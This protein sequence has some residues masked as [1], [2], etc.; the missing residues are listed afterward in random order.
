MAQAQITINAVA[1]SNDDLPIATL[2]QLNNNNGG[3]EI[4]YA[5]SIIDQPPGAADALSNPAIQNPTLTP[6]KEGTYLLRLVVNAGPNQLTDEVI[7]AVR[8]VKSRQ[9][10]PAAGEEAEDGARGWAGAIGSDMSYLDSQLNLQAGT[11]VVYNGSGSTRS[12]GEVVQLLSQ[13]T[14]KSGLPGQELM[15]SAILAAFGSIIAANDRGAHGPLALVETQPDG[16][17]TAP[18][19]SLMVVRVFGMFTSYPFGSMSASGLPLAL[20][21]AGLLQETANGGIYQGRAMGTSLSSGTNFS[22]FFNGLGTVPSV[23]PI[24]FGSASQFGLGAGDYYLPPG[25]DSIGTAFITPLRIPVGYFGVAYGMYYFARTVGTAPTTLILRKNN[26]D[27]ALTL[28]LSG[29][30]G[31]ALLSSPIEF[32]PTDDIAVLGRATGSGSAYADI[33]VTLGMIPTRLIS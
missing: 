11:I 26:A 20:T 19:G 4:S 29:A 25:Y 17:T 7:A 9:R 15:P 14:I 8:F 1:G 24:V 2:V 27:T 30:S 10:V 3:G 12:R 23:A 16:T 28:V 6:N 33:F 32:S 21:S 5:W 31:H 13:Q 18:A 22:L